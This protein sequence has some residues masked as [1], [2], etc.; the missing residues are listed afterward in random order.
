ME[1][2]NLKTLFGQVMVTR[3]CVISNHPASDSRMGATFTTV[4]L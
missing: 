2:H 4:E 1:F 3:E